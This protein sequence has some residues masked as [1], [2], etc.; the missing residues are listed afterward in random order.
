M[1]EHLLWKN[2][3][4]ILPRTHVSKRSRGREGEE[5]EGKGRVRVIA[6]S[7]VIAIVE[8]LIA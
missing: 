6:I 3:I 2:L 1:F 4:G 8:N 5:R 7:I